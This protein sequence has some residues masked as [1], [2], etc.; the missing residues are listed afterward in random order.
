MATRK[1]IRASRYDREQL[2]G[3]IFVAPFVAGFLVIFVQ[4]IFNSVAFGFSDMVV[5]ATGYNLKWNN[6]ANYYE[7]LFVNADV[8]KTT[9][10]AIMETFTQVPLIIIFSLFTACMLNQEFKGRAVF[11][12][13]FFVPV[14]LSTGV[15][16]QLQNNDVLLRAMSS[17]SGFNT[18]VSSDTTGALL[19]V[20]DV[21]KYISNI[22]FSPEIVN[23]A[24]SAANNIYNVVTQSGVQ[25]LLFLAALQAISP[26]IYESAAMEGASGWEIFWKIT[27]PMLTPMILANM[28]FTIV[29]SFTNPTNSMMALIN[30]LS[31][32]QSRYGLS[33]AVSWTYCVII[34]L[35]MGL[36]FLIFSRFVF[37]QQRTG[38]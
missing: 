35:F 13:I 31:F 18:G 15:I 33:A 24:V 7:M 28:V 36:A 1:R 20:L 25:I 12:A 9:V 3:W 14:V 21:E 22:Q 26:S 23:Y 6:F 38:K 32:Q 29:D 17:T 5:T 2:K 19:S 27:L 37:Y 30:K 8:L 10:S 34:A 4:V 11:R 16:L